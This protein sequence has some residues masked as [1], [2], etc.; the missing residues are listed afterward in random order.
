GT[1]AA[2][3]VIAIDRQVHP[4]TVGR[5]R[6]D[7]LCRGLRI[8]LDNENAASRIGHGLASR[9]Y[10]R[11]GRSYHGSKERKLTYLSETDPFVICM[12]FLSLQSLAQSGRQRSS[13]RPLVAS[14]SGD[15]TT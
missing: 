8:V 4:V 3:P 10:R 12:F 15:S 11:D 7:K 13:G 6:I 9:R 5:E 14:T 2:Q 1:P